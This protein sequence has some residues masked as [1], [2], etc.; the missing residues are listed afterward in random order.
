MSDPLRGFA[1]DNTAGASPEILAA[2]AACARGQAR[3]Y[4]DDELTGRV[5]R[6]LQDLFEC[7]L[8]V[9]L[10]PTGTAA[11]ALALAALS[12]PWGAVLCHRDAHVANDECGAPE[13]YG[14]GLK[15]VAVGGE[16]ATPDLG[17]LRAQAILNR[18]DVHAVQP[19]AV[20]VTQISEAGAVLSLDEI[21]AI[22]ALCRELGL[23]LHMDGARFANALVALG[24]TPAEMTWR[25]GVSLLSFGAT[26]N[27]ALGAEALVV[28][29]RTLTPALHYRR[30]RAGQL[31]SKMRFLAAQ[32]DAYLEGDLWLRNAR[33]AN[34]MAARLADGLARLPGV[35]LRRPAEANIVFA[36]LPGHVSRGLL[37]RGY[38]FHPDRREPGCFRFVT[39]FETSTA[40]VEAFLAAAGGLA[41]SR[42]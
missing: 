7:E 38:L 26:K 29:D 36:R 14:A 39:S 1:S 22:G 33:H 15:L 23:G 6:R 5:A 9:L 11:N 35:S 2:I 17:E 16:G 24:C 42:G 25:R 4:G 21:E 30:K 8:D 13:F 28:F 18:G 10:V 37:E 20:T 34:S 27:G 12:P 31:A 3:P 41:S 19:S 40:E 32:M